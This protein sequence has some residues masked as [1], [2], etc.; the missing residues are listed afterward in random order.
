M[1][2]A[3]ER[4]NRQWLVEPMRPNE[5]RIHVDVGEGAEISEEARTALESLLDELQK[6]EVEG[7]AIFPPCPELSACH[8]FQCVPPGKCD[9]S[10]VPCF[11]NV[12]CWIRR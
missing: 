7:L 3:D 10:S 2:A 1:A 4:A 11:A 5:V 12:V 6:S 9:L 8:G